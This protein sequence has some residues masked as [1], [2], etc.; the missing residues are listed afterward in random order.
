MLSPRDLG[1]GV[2][3]I[4]R[5]FLDAGHMR[6][7]IAS[8]MHLR[9]VWVIGFT[10]FAAKK[11]IPEIATHRRA[12]P[13]ARSARCPITLRGRFFSGSNFRSSC[14]CCSDRTACSTASLI[15]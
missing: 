6:E 8:A 12:M 11:A 3:Q 1:L 7:A 9:D 4:F 10:G 2:D 5:G 13:F 14:K 15:S